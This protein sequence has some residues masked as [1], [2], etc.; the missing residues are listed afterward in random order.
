MAKDDDDS[1]PSAFRQWQIKRTAEADTKRL[2]SP[3]SDDYVSF[4]DDDEVDPVQD[5]HVKSILAAYQPVGL[6]SIQTI[7]GFIATGKALI[8]AKEDRKLRRDRFLHMF[9]DPDHDHEGPLTFGKS[10]GEAFMKIARNAV[11]TNPNN[12]GKLRASWAVLSDLTQMPDA[13]LQ[14]VVDSGK[15]KEISR[16]EA[17]KLI[18]KYVGFRP[19]KLRGAL[20]VIVRCLGRGM[21]GD[22]Y[23]DQIAVTDS[24]S[25]D[26]WSDSDLRLMESD[27]GYIGEVGQRLRERQEEDDKVIAAEKERMEEETHLANRAAV[28]RVR[29]QKAKPP[30]EYV[31]KEQDPPSQA[32]TAGSKKSS[33]VRVRKTKRSH[34]DGS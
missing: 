6:G 33:Q 30:E 12:I 23:G 2:S 11:L 1:V 9:D 3:E 24:E 18:E 15:V 20:R 13:P 28:A 26:F 19:D 5:A 25:K 29:A 27:T 16:A 4:E 14:S 10:K 7:E 34:P 32:E 17:R 8:K 31:E 22:K 21:T